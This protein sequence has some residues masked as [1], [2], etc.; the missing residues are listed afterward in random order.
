MSVRP[1]AWEVLPKRIRLR[2]TILYFIMHEQGLKEKQATQK[3]PETISSSPEVATEPPTS[4]RSITRDLPQVEDK[5]LSASTRP[6][7]SI[8]KWRLVSLYVRYE[9]T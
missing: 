7:V 2:R 3:L 8:S 9:I 1:S 5:E 4:T 6:K